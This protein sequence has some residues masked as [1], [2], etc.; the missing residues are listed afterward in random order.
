MLIH[1][2]LYAR[3]KFLKISE[4]QKFCLSME[5]V[6]AS[7]KQGD[8]VLCSLRGKKSG[9]KNYLV[10]K[11]FPHESLKCGNVGFCT[12]FAIGKYCN[13]KVAGFSAQR[14]CLF[15]VVYQEHK[16]L[17]AALSPPRGAQDCART[18]E[19]SAFHKHIHSNE[20]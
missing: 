6:L 13:L 12:K 9:M 14:C 11:I 8:M 20:R 7:I 15:S 4:F 3:Y 19:A 16:C 18:P 5:F 10:P 2:L 17:Q 1:Q